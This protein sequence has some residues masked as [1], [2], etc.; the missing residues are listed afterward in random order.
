MNRVETPDELAIN[1]IKYISLDE[2]EGVTRLRI[3][4]DANDIEPGLMVSHCGT[5]S[6]AEQV[7]ETRTVH[8]PAATSR[9]MPIDGQTRISVAPR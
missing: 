1:P 4:I 6:A 5:A 8:S 9:A 3:D 7:E 2:L